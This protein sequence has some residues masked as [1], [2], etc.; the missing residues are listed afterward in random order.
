MIVQEYGKTYNMKTISLR[1]GCLTEVAIMEQKAHGFLSY[2]INSIK[3]DMEYT[4]EGYEG[5]QEEI[6]FT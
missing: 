3:N 6:T 2:L 5:L 4:I 1:G